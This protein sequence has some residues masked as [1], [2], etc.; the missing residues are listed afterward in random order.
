MPLDLPKFKL[1][2]LN[3]FA[4]G[5]LNE[6]VNLSI[7]FLKNL[8]RDKTMKYKS[9]FS[10]GMGIFLN[11]LCLTSANALTFSFS[12]QYEVE[13]I[14]GIFTATDLNNDLSISEN[15][16][17]DFSAILT[18]NN[19][20]KI[21]EITS[22]E[23]KDISTFEYTIGQNDKLVFVVATTDRQIPGGFPNDI[24]LAFNVDFQRIEDEFRDGDAIAL[25]YDDQS[26]GTVEV[27]SD[28]GIDPDSNTQIPEPT[29]IIALLLLG[30]LGAISR[31]R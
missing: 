11:S 4:Y 12:R 1:L 30:G 25:L 28:G 22:D 8:Y 23:G 29:S 27:I 14:R 6:R 13:V 9:L 18:D 20:V 7:S 15:E 24:N 26:T 3:G 17:T 5:A 31:L 10:L 19:G 16:V 21:D 2:C